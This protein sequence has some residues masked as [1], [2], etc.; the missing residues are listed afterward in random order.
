MGAREQQ[1][2]KPLSSYPVNE[3]SGCFQQCSRAA[4]R[5]LSSHFAFS[6]LYCAFETATRLLG[7]FTAQELASLLK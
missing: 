2:R 3:V 7:L 1:V 6:W 5:G 4:A